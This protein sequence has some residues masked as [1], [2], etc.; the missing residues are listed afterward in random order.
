MGEKIW[1]N[2]KVTRKWRDK[3]VVS[4]AIS[5]EANRKKVIFFLPTTTSNELCE[6]FARPTALALD[7]HA[8][9]TR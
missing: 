8:T 4:E 7:P 6:H 3:E 5:S 1:K 2:E 9:H